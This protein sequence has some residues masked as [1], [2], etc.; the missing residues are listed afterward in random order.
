MPKFSVDSIGRTDATS[1]SYAPWNPQ[2]RIDATD[3]AFLRLVDSIRDYGQFMPVL[4]NYMGL[5]IDGNRRVAACRM[6]D[7]PVLYVVVPNADARLIYREVNR[8]QQ[9][10]AGAQLAE[11]Y[12]IDPEALT[13]KQKKRIQRFA[14]AFGGS[15]PF[16]EFLRGTNIKMRASMTRAA[17]VI[18]AAEGLQIK[19]G[20]DTF[21]LAK[22]AQTHNEF[23]SLCEIRDHSHIIAQVPELKDWVMGH[24]LNDVP[25]P[26]KRG[27]AGRVEIE[28]IVAECVDGEITEADSVI[29]DGTFVVC[30]CSWWSSKSATIR[31]GEPYSIERELSILDSGWFR[32]LVIC[33]MR[34]KGKI[35]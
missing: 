17:W 30:T 13:E 28:D 29:K 23:K 33:K 6:L 27:R 2:S 35:A 20:N 9:S 8:L 22:W 7:K 26:V 32:D 1:L 21:M 24:V 25:L 3:N 18:S 19:P 11:I 4:I 5:I 16:L 31:R 15:K 12:A 34:E 10:I 14:I